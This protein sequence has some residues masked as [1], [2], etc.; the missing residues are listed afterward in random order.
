MIHRDYD[1]EALK[2]G[3]E[4][5]KPLQTEIPTSHEIIIEDL[6]AF[7]LLEVA[8]KYGRGDGSGDNPLSYHNLIH[9]ENVMKAA[10]AIARLAVEAGKIDDSDV[11]LVEIA[12]AYHDV[13]HGLGRGVSEDVSASIAEQQMRKAGVFDGADIAKVVGMIRATK[14]HFDEAGIMKQAASP[15]DYLTKIIADAD[16]HLLGSPTEEQ[17]NGAIALLHEISDTDS[18]TPEQE[19]AFFQNQLKLFEN[20]EYYTN[21]AVQL[22]SYKAVNSAHAAALVNS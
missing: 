19:H 21:E 13:E 22:Y 3:S 20:H 9:T 12:A 11:T 17:H 14:V 10:G 1:V 7:A 16:L 2:I 8:G 5:Q 15:D 4:E 18:P 6:K